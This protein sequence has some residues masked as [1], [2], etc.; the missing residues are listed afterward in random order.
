[1]HTEDKQRFPYVWDYDIDEQQFRQILDGHLSIGR[2]DQDW[3]H[4]TAIGICSL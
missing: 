2:L 3:A 1:M 4:G